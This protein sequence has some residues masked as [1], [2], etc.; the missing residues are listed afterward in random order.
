MRQ[1]WND[2]LSKRLGDEG[3]AWFVDRGSRQIAKCTV[4]NGTGAVEAEK[5]S[6]G[7]PAYTQHKDCGYCARYVHRLEQFTFSYFEGVPAAYRKHTLSQLKP[8]AGT[9]KAVSLERQQAIL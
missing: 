1:L 8:Y 6:N 3:Y 5:K 9:A 4:C 2:S 7:S